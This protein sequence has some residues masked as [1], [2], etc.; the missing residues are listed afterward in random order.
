MN[1]CHA[2][3]LT[4]LLL[5]SAA[6][7]EPVKPPLTP[8]IITATRQVTLFTGLEKTMLQA[9]QKKDKNA[10]D[11]MLSDECFISIPKSDPL[12]C[13]DWADSVTAGDFALK[14]FVVRRVSVTDLGDSAL[15]SFERVQQA[16]HGAKNLNGEF[17]VVDL[18]RKSGNSWKLAS[19][20]VSRME[21]ASPEPA[22]PPKPTGKE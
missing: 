12:D 13:S 3:L 18:W 9:V 16:T 2:G 17:F 11:G 22:A 7:Q 19:R 21:I 14:S 15:V 20:Y 8:R 6:A 5:A 4:S 1:L 10:L